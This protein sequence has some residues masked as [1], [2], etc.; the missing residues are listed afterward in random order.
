MKVQLNYKPCLKLY[1]CFTCLVVLATYTLVL[2]SLD[3][4]TFHANFLGL[5]SLNRLDLNSKCSVAL[6]IVTPWG[7]SY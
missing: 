5:V 2:F 6:M 4:R 3:V 7:S 1:M